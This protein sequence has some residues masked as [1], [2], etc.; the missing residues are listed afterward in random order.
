M[1]IKIILFIAFVLVAVFVVSLLKIPKEKSF[2]KLPYKKRNLMTESELNF[3][4][5]LEQKY[6]SQY[7][8]IPQVLL[9]SIIDVDLPKRFF[10]YRGYRSKIDKKTIDF[11]LFDKQNYNPVLAIELDDSTHSKSEAERNDNFKNG[12]FNKVGIK[13]TRVS[14]SKNYNFTEFL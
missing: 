9:S 10:A 12:V 13:L 7:Y 2:Q 6:N 11:V 5:Q 3:F 1:I 4:R 8:I 14:V